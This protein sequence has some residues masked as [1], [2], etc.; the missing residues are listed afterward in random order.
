MRKTTTL[1]CAAALITVMG[2]DPDEP[3]VT[4]DAGVTTHDTGTTDVDAYTPTTGHDGGTVTTTVGTCAMPIDLATAGEALASGVGRQIVMSNASAAASTIGS[5]PAA[6]CAIL[7][8]ASNAV[9]FTY[10][11]TTDAYLVATTED[12]DTAETMDTVVWILD[13]CST[14]ATELGCSDD[15]DEN[16]EHYLSNAISTQRFAAGTEL[17]IVVAS[18]V[19]SGSEPGEFHLR[20]VELQPNA[21]GAACGSANPLCVDGHSCQLDEGSEDS[22]HCLADGSEF[23]ACRETGAACDAGLECEPN[24]ETCQTPIAVGDP[25]SARHL[26]CAA[27]GSCQLEDGSF[28]DMRCTADGAEFGECSLTDPHCEGTLVCTS[29]TPSADDPGLCLVENP[30]DG[31]C[32]YWSWQCVAGY[33]CMGDVDPATGDVSDRDGHCLADGGEG[34]PCREEGEPCDAGL[35]CDD[36]WGYCFPIED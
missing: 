35:E 29:S 22:G 16:E 31:P 3:A 4:D 11:M 32:S 28:E 1:L 6:E 26:L 25:C 2:C 10:T 24:A 20:L 36:L 14:S 23:G 12:D 34:R 8:E 5:V 9:I 21:A 27:G 7:D 33:S 17:F 19:W 18:S 13:G 30:A 15:S